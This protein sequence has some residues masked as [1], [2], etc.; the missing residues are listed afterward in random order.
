MSHGRR[1]ILIGLAPPEDPFPEI[2]NQEYNTETKPS[3]CRTG[4]GWQITLRNINDWELQSLAE[5]LCDLEGYQ[6]FIQR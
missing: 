6:G 3:Q 1:I 4:E 2:N 5:I